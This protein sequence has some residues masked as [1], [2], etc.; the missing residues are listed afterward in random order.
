M[1]IW[2]PR[3]RDLGTYGDL[4]RMF[5]PPPV[6][7]VVES[8]D[9]PAA[10]CAVESVPTQLDSDVAEEAVEWLT[11]LQ[12]AVEVELRSGCHV[13][14]TKVHLE[15]ALFSIQEMLEPATRWLQSER[16]RATEGFAFAFD[17]EDIARVQSE[18]VDLLARSKTLPQG[19]PYI[20]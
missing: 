20:S 12:K 17:C 8:P 1:H 15:S 16:S 5:G 14:P 11:P 19:P 2:G 7:E 18:V 9:I 10:Q 13:G 6:L 3:F 4:K